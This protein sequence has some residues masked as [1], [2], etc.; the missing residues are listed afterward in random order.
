MN[1]DVSIPPLR[2]LP[3]A[4][5]AQR[6]EHL[7]SE[8]AQPPLR[9]PLPRRGLLAVPTV[10]AIAVAIVAVAALLATPALGIGDRLLSLI[11]SKPTPLDVQAPAWSPDGRTIVF[12]SGRDGNGEVYAMD[13]DGTSPRNLTQDP[14]QDVH[15]A[16]SPD[17][18][19]IAFVSSR[20][21]S[22]R[23]KPGPGPCWGRDRQSEIYVMN[24]DGSRKRNLTRRAND[25]YPT[26]SPDGRRIAFLRA[27]GSYRHHRYHLYV[28]NA[29]GSGLRNLMQIAAVAYFSS[30]LVWSPDGRTIYFGRYLISTDGSGARKLPYIPLIAVWS[31]D[32]RQIAFVGNRAT[33]LPGPGARSK[34]DS[35]IYVM[36]A[37]GSGTRRLTHNLGYDG[38]PAWSPDGR[39]IAFQSHRRVGGSK[40]EIYVMNAD[41]S[42]K[43]NLTR[44]PANDGSP[45]WSP[46]GRRIAF[47]SNRDGRPEAHVMNADGSGQ[48]SLASQE[49]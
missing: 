37:D 24:A 8:I 12:V 39:K 27:T 2:D 15:P 3:P 30:H 32:G 46:D 31:P 11:Q 19:R 21:P 38:E 49:G 26:W 41:G 10:V 36:N 1:G 25:D 34:D 13:A 42:G 4:R 17:G 9:S 33:G 6:R 47:V 5:L 16:W 28:M 7:L 45:S 22:S 44:N 23:C 40:A 48:R 14:A 43:R 18:R 20:S 35:E 29:D